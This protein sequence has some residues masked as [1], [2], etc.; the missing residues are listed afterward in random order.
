M[1]VILS[2]LPPTWDISS[3]RSLDQ[4]GARTAAPTSEKRTL[5]VSAARLAADEPDRLARKSVA[6]AAVV[7]LF[8]LSVGTAFTVLVALVAVVRLSAPSFALF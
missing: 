7:H 1:T 6:W 5:F 4:I 3:V 8:A 2:F